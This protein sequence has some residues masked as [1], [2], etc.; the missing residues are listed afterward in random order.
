MKKLLLGTLAGLSAIGITGCG[1]T[2]Q[3]RGLNNDAAGSRTTTGASHANR[4][5][6]QNTNVGGNATNLD[7]GTTSST[8]GN[9]GAGTS[10]KGKGSG[11]GG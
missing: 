8:G 11:A 10:P 9:A 3:R 2:G 6:T 5:A 4:G 1:D 7:T